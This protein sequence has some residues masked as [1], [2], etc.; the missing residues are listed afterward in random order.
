[1]IEHLLSQLALAPDPIRDLQ[2]LVPLGQ[3]GDEVEEVVGFALESEGVQ[4]PEQERRI[5]QPAVA[6]VV[7]PLSPRRLG[8]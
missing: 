3:L 4:P 8:E 7:V 2:A 6:I 5:T 1:V